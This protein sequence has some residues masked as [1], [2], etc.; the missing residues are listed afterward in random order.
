MKFIVPIILFFCLHYSYACTT[1][2]IG[3]DAT[4]DGSVILAHNEDMGKN[5]A[6]LLNYYKGQEYPPGTLIKVP[7]IEL[8]QVSRTLSFWGA[9]NAKN[10]SGLGV[11]GELPYA[12]NHIL[13]GMNENGV[14]LACNW[15]NSKDENL[16]EIGIRRYA[17]RQLVLERAKTAKNAV[18]IITKFIDT[19]GQADWGG[20]TYNVADNNEAWIIETTSIH[21]IARRIRDNEIWTVAN[22]FTITDDYDIASEGL[23]DYAWDKNW[24]STKKEKI[25]FRT[26]FGK[27]PENAQAY[28]I[29]RENLVQQELS[30][31]KG[32]IDIRM[33]MSVLKHRYQDEENFKPITE[34]CWRDY[35]EEKKVRRPL[36]SCLTQSSMIATL[37]PK[38][39]D[40]GGKMWY[41]H[42]SPHVG[43]YFPLYGRVYR[44]APDFEN[45]DGQDKD[46]NWW[47][48]RQLQ[49]RIDEN[50]SSQFN[51]F[52]KLQDK[53]QNKVLTKNVKFEMS[54]KQ[55]LEAWERHQAILSKMSKQI[56]SN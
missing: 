11:G 4:R 46:S 40:I 31:H 24:I 27:F 51:E 19:Y 3:K 26:V 39:K 47:S 2:L 21:W 25:N 36:S 5:T 38:Y 15:M 53:I 54:D 6:G 55:N 28:D 18:D 1:I 23:V 13:V 20:L 12:Y 42:A 41:L 8:G 32:D 16:K 22:R 45:E 7:Y 44:I 17:I 10:V 49:S 48:S 33:V 37:H 9:G 29:G 14:A 43:I 52:K 50:Y 30:K 35:C 56:F 34:E